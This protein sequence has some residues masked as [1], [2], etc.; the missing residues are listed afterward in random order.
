MPQSIKKSLLAKEED[1]GEGLKQLCKKGKVLICPL[2]LMSF[3]WFL[4]GFV[5][6]GIYFGVKYLEADIYLAG[7]VIGVSEILGYPAG[8]VM[9]HLL[10]RKKNAIV[11]C[12]FSVVFCALYLASSWLDWN[13]ALILLFAGFCNLGINVANSSL[14]LMTAELFPT[15]Y[16][17]TVFG[18]VNIFGRVGG[19]LSPLINEYLKKDSMFM[20]VFGAFMFAL[21]CLIMFLPE[22]KE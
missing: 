11:G 5:N 21:G 22:T 10:G 19:V 4:M 9:I 20:V 3:S 18:V 15:I 1:K 7:V 13:V 8:G 17:A 6:Y 14:Y 2:I 16:R 12:I